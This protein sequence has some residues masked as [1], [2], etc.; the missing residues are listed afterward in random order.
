[1]AILDQK[2]LLKLGRLSRSSYYL[3]LLA[4]L[5]AV[6]LFIMVIPVE[7]ILVSSVL[8]QKKRWVWI[9]LWMVAGSAIGALILSLLT[10]HYGLPFVQTFWPH[11]LESETWTS[12]SKFLEDWGLWAMA[13]IAGSFLPQQPAVII[14][15]LSRMSVGVIV[16]SVIMGRSV[17][18]FA[19]SFA[20]S[21]GHKWIKKYSRVK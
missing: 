5:A 11:L 21:H 17:K 4:V 9:S 3:P 7:A 2:W 18:Y 8:L 13:I 19:F 15:G 1:M 10:Q 16:L 12:T 14:A 6:D 20:A